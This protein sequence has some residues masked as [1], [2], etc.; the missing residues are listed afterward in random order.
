MRL[1]ARQPSE[2]HN[3]SDAAADDILSPVHST[4]SILELAMSVASGCL[5][6][7]DIESEKVSLPSD[8]VMSLTSD[9]SLLDTAS[10]ADAI[11]N[12][13]PPSPHMEMEDTLLDADLDD[14]LWPSIDAMSAIAYE[15]LFNGEF[16]SSISD[17]EMPAANIPSNVASDETCIRT[18]CQESWTS[19][20]NT[21]VT[22]STDRADMYCGTALQ[23]GSASAHEATPAAND[24]TNDAPPGHMESEGTSTGIDLD[25]QGA[26]L[27]S[28]EVSVRRS[29][30]PPMTL[31]TL[32]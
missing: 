14:I 16:R 22:K 15:P 28:R 24:V 19:P 17:H 6:L 4:S 27:R 2:L 10:G 21:A 25:R 1:Y 8:D 31:Q 29:M 30:C 20:H 23:A 13:I 9:I 7:L 11:E 18:G 26:K 12:I 32:T 5:S 3:P